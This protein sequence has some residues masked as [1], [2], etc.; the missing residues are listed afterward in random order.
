VYGSYTK[1][2][3]KALGSLEKWNKYLGTQFKKLIVV[4]LENQRN[5]HAVE[6]DSDLIMEPKFMI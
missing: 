6:L 5:F 3:V 1:F 4:K 2:K